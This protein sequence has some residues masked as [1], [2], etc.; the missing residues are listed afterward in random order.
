MSTFQS[1]AGEYVLERKG[2]VAAT[3]GHYNKPFADL[4]ME[5]KKNSR[6][7]GLGSYLL[8]EL[9][10]ECYLSGRIP[11]ARCNIENMASKATLIKAGLRICGFMLT[12]RVKK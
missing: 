12:G 4:Y 9:K 3:G 2:E 8:Q 11:A 6:R 7:I 10:K 5:V 1:R